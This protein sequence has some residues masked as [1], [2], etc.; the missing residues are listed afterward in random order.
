MTASFRHEV[1]LDAPVEHVLAVL[2]DPASHAARYAAAGASGA[3]VVDRDPDADGR[4]T[5]VSRR[6][7]GGSL[8]G[9]IARL[10]RGSAQVTQTERWSA[11]AADGACS[12]TWTVVTRG[13][14]V[15]IDGTTDVRPHGPGTRLIQTGVITARVPLLG[16]LMEKVAVDQSASKLALEW[17][18]LAQHL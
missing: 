13:V 4:L 1:D 7:E 14:P 12:A 2:R 18:W 8:P 5:I 16:T 6:A 17:A 15:D 10:V 9:P 11:P 3:E